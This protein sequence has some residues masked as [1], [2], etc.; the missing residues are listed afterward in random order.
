MTRRNL[1]ALA[2]A[3]AFAAERRNR[4]PVSHE[5]LVV[6]LPEAEPVKLP[7]G[8]TVMAIED[9]RLPIAYVRF[10]IEG[11]GPIYGRPGVAELTADM[12]REGAAGRS[13]KQIVDEAA[14]LGATLGT[15]APSGA[16]VAT[17]DGSG[18]SGHVFEWSELLS[19]VVVLRPSFPADEFNTL[20]QRRLQEIRLRR[21]QPIVADDVLQRLVWGS[22]PAA[23]AVPSAEVLASLNPEALAAWHRERYT[24]SSALVACIGR[25]RSSLFVSRAEKLLGAWKGPEVNTT[26]P[27]PPA[28]SARRIVLIDRPGAPQTELAVGGL[29]FDRRD[30]DFFP[31]S[32]LNSALGTGPASRL[33][34]ILRSE[35]AY[36][37][38]AS[39]SFGATRFAGLWKVRAGVRT[40]ATADSIAIILTQLR[41]ICDE[42]IPAAEL[43]EAKTSVVG[44]FALTLEQPQQVIAQSYLR[45]RYGFSVDYW[46][47]YPARLTAV[48]ASEIQAVARKY[49]DPDRAHIV[50][51][52]DAARIRGALDKVGHVE[53]MA[54]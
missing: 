12:L 14:R 17:V 40:D 39:S 22:H 21:I 16:E 49:L 5:N 9:D 45:H 7:N 38:N 11:A 26:L 48:T 3:G 46:E 37:Y 50:A 32:V 31:M 6:K 41:R 8:V 36:A 34:Q 2:A 25:V 52:G 33:F 20:R 29:L 18:L 13:G 19:S 4:A 43:D 10:H 1:F 42:P 23:V 15:S 27:P 44:R 53:S 35:K 51:V 24:P 54:A 28:P 47:R 30:P